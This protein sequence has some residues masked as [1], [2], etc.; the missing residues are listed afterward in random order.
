M[1]AFCFPDVIISSNPMD[2]TVCSTSRNIITMPCGFIGA[3]STTLPYWRIIRRNSN[4]SVI[5]NIT[6]S[7]DDIDDHDGLVWVPDTTSVPQYSYDSALL[8]GP[9]DETYNQSSYQCFVLS[10]DGNVTESD[11]GTITIIGECILC[12]NNIW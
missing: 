12:T 2:T 4:G 11:V 5:S 10:H 3:P 7:G 8:V 1:F 9:V 6:V